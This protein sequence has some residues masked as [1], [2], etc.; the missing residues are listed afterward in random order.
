MVIRRSHLML[1]SIC[2]FTLM[3]CACSPNEV[4][5]IETVITVVSGIIGIASAAG[6]VILPAE[7]VLITDAASIIQNSLKSLANVVKGYQSNPNAT[8]LQEVQAAFTDLQNNLPQLLTAAQVKDP[9]TAA[10]LTAAVNAVAQT[11]AVIEVS[12]VGNSADK[13]ASAPP[14]A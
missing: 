10:K 14:A 13:I 7:S 5:A 12:V 9:A 8:T 3:L 2:C 4:G 11:I 1:I 6:S